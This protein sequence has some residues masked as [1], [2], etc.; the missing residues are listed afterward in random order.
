MGAEV[1][2]KPTAKNFNKAAYAA[3]LIT[4]II[5][6]VL[7]DFS[8]T[9]IFW[10]WALVFDPFDPAVLFQKRP[11]LSAVVADSAPIYYICIFCAADF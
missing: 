5:F 11:R 6:M 4:G 9:S 7:K 2:T 1:K 10:V 3:F 8:Q